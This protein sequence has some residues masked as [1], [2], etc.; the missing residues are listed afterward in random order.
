MAGTESHLDTT[1]RDARTYLNSQLD[2]GKAAKCPACT[3]TV[4]VYPRKIYSTMV[5]HL[6][7]LYKLNKVKAEYYHVTE[8]CP[9]HPGDFA[10][11]VY[12]NLIEEMPKD[13]H[14]THKRTSGYW[15]ITE[16]GKKFVENK[17]TVAQTVDVFNG[18]P[19]R[20]HGN[21][22]TIVEVLGKKFS[23]KELMEDRDVRTTSP[24]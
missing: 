10:K 19:L 20:M 11:L 7:E 4:K 18:N 8:F 24:I 21:P 17:L 15:K 9:K 23:Y 3:Q 2:K 6:I 16:M 12:W 1:I 13:E 5:Y 14:D 22:V